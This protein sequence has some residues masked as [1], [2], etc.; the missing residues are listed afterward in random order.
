MKVSKRGEESK[1]ER[2]SVIISL[3][4]RESLLF[5]VALDQGDLSL[6]LISAPSNL[7]YRSDYVSFTI[8]ALSW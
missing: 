6:D 1:L 7:S 8:H 5:S 2:L 3:T 4:A